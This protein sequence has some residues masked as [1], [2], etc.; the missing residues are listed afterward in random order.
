[1]RRRRAIGWL[2][3]RAAWETARKA[4]YGESWQSLQERDLWEMRRDV[5]L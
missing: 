2:F 5:S 3:R 1:M 4:L